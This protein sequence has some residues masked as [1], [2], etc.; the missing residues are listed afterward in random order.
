[1]LL[2]YNNRV[3][4][5]EKVT[6]KFKFLVIVRRYWGIGLLYVRTVYAPAVPVT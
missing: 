6:K 5:N 4:F 3:G 1:M 2:S